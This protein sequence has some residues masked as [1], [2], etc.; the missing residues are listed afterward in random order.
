MNYIVLNGKKS[1]DIIGLLIQSLPPISKPL[2]RTQIQEIDGR[3]G[4]I[5]TKLGYAAYDKQ[6][7]I[8]LHGDFNIDDVIEYFD[9]S[10]TVIFSNEPDK[11]YNYQ[12]IAQ[13]DF[14]RLIRFR[15][16]KVTLH[17]Q[18]FKYDAMEPVLRKSMNVPITIPNKTMTASGVT[19]TAEEN[20]LAISGTATTGTEIYFPIQA[21]SMNAGNY[22][23]TAFASGTGSQA[24]SMRLIT[25][26]PSSAN[27]FGGNYV[28][29]QNGN[30]VT[31]SAEL[32][33]TKVFNYLYFYIAAG[34]AM[35]FT[36][37]IEITND[38][39]RSVTVRNAGNIYSRPKITV[40]GSGTVNLYLNNN[41]IFVIDIGNDQY[42]TIDSAQMN[43]YKDSPEQLKNRLVTGDYDNFILNIGKNVLSW[44]GNVTEIDV[45]NYSR[46]I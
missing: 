18:P 4:D 10:G 31:I 11:Y 24:C 44:T 29:L 2:M 27:S 36:L 13:I 28:T 32:T 20:S 42:I 5:I 35:D 3:D 39:V 30:A 23:L 43:A 16:A 19:V 26:S 46:W 15:T 22:T 1:T 45:A 7:S 14:E 37:D 21:L 9:S 38:D 41:Q 33:A 25:D 40:Y 6:I 12:I 17:C 8:G 34:T